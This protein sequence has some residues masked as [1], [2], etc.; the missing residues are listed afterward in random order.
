[1]IRYDEDI[2]DGLDKAPETFLGMLE[3][4]NFGKVLIR[5]TA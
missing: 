4:K 5:L 3:G 2:T 1:M